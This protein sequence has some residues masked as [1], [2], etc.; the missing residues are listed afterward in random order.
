MIENDIENHLLKKSTGYIV[1]QCFAE[2]PLTR[3]SQRCIYSV[4]MFPYQR[5]KPIS[6][7]SP[8]SPCVRRD[9]EAVEDW[10]E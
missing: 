10:P 2:A 6:M 3:Y 8:N 7:D 1:Q 5:R 9:M 4:D